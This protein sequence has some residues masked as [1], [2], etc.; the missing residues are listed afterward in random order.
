M[1]LLLD[2]PLLLAPA[3][4]L[5]GEGVAGD[6]KDK[7]KNDVVAIIIIIIIIIIILILIIIMSYYCNYNY[8]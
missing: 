7:W 1:R 8:T 3:P 4:L 6:V 2:G 5:A